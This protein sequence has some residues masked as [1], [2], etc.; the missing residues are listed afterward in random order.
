MNDRDHWAVQRRRTRLWR[1][2]A[3]TAALQLGRSPAA[4]ARPPCTV[5]IT[6]P[7]RAARTRDPHNWAPTMKA[8]IDGLVDAGVWPDDNAAWV[9]TTEPVLS[10][11]SSDVV[12]ELT[13]RPD[14]AA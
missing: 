12:V 7:V 6:I 9:T 13:P 8:V 11:T 3:H 10:T 4:R 1:Q 5:T 2:T 14:E